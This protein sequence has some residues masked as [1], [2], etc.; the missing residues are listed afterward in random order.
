MSK[1]DRVLKAYE[2]AKEAYAAWG[3]DAD[4]A[5]KKIGNVPIS[6]HSW[7]GDDVIGFHAEALTGGSATTGNYPGRPTNSDQL[8]PAPHCPLFNSSAAPAGATRDIV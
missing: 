2:L 1:Q 4:A 6:T 7:Q 8:P 5:I 3:V